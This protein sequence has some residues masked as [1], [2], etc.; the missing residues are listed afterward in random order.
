LNG[1]TLAVAV[2]DNNSISN[3]DDNLNIVATA[4]AGVAT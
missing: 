4:L 2:E 3:G 1:V